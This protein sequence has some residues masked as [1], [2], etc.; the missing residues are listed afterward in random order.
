MQRILCLFGKHS[1][2]YIRIR[3]AWHCVVCRKQIRFA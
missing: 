3:Q 2:G 1:D